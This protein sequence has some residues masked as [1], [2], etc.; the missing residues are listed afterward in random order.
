MAL[1]GAACALLMA[2]VAGVCARAPAHAEVRWA[3]TA[4]GPKHQHSLSAHLP[5]RQQGLVGVQ[6]SPVQG[7]LELPRPANKP[8][9]F[10]PR[11]DTRP[12]PAIRPEALLAE[13]TRRRLSCVLPTS[14][15]RIADRPVVANCPAQGPPRTA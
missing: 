3:T 8:L 10:Q 2:V 1:V 5:V 9:P 7:Q 12:G 11:S 15:G 6:A 14:H 13:R 4:R